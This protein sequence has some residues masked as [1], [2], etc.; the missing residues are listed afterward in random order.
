LSC[1]RETSYRWYHRTK[2]LIGV[3]EKQSAIT[4]LE[5]ERFMR[6]F[7]KDKTR[8]GAPSVYTFEQ[9]CR[10]VVIATEKP[11]KYGI[12]SAKWTHWEL[13]MTTARNG[14]TNSISPSSV[15]RILAEAS[16][17]QNPNIEDNNAFNGK[18]GKICDIYH[19]SERELNNQTHT[20]SVDEKK[21][22][23]LF[24]RSF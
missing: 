16:I 18:V 5:L 10:I 4:D 24:C 2:E 3:F 6:L 9:Q 22:I 11:K 8:P 14:I 13:A 23:N 20:V 12:Q 17:K 19:N 7:L 15:G 1:N 21:G